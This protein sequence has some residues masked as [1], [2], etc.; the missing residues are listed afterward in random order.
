MPE[1]RITS[2]TFAVDKTLTRFRTRLFAAPTLERLSSPS[3]ASKTSNCGPRTP[4]SC[5][6]C[7]PGLPTH[8]TGCSD[9]ATRGP[10]TASPSIRGPSCYWRPFKQFKTEKNCERRFTFPT[11]SQARRS[12]RHLRTPAMPVDAQRRGWTS[13]PLLHICS[14]VLHQCSIARMFGALNL[15]ES[16]GGWTAVVH[17]ACYCRP[18]RLKFSRVIEIPKTA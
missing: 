5:Q 12:R 6:Q 9:A 3:P 7:S 8:L 16:C 13:H 18:K 10:S 1:S 11:A 2:E 17:G 15:L 4:M 14:R